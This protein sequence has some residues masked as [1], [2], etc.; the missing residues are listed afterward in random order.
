VPFAIA[1]A[2]TQKQRKDQ[3]EVAELVRRGVPAAPIRTNTDGGM[4][5]VFRDALKG[6]SITDSDG[7]IRPITFVA[8]PGTIPSHVNPPR[9]PNPVFAPEGATG[10]VP[11]VAPAPAAPASSTAFAGVPLPRPAPHA[12]SGGS[13]FGVASAVPSRPAPPPAAPAQPVVWGAPPPGTAAAVPGTRALGLRGSEPK[14]AEARKPS[15]WPAP[16]ATAAAQPPK[17]ATAEATPPAPAASKQT[18]P[19]AQPA[20][21]A[22]SFDSRWGAFR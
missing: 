22:G 4:H 9:D 2:L 6:P 20:L 5:K 3:I 8:A 13:T 12:K 16:G 10:A 17:Q 7:R 18:V 1:S 19:G 21:P 15:P 14:P 11:E